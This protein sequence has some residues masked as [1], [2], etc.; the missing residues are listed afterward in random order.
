MT[1][2]Y[3]V[4]LWSG[5][6]LRIK[7]GLNQSRT[8]SMTTVFVHNQY[9]KRNKWHQHGVKTGGSQPYTWPPTQESGG[10]L[11]PPDLQDRRHCRTEPCHARSI[12]IRSKCQE[13]KNFLIVKCKKNEKITLYASTERRRK[14]RAELAS[15]MVHCADFVHNPP[16]ITTTTQNHG[17]GWPKNAARAQN[18]GINGDRNYVIFTPL[19]M[20]HRS[21]KSVHP[22][23]PVGVTKRPKKIQ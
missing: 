12:Q 19:R 22:L 21:L 8:W 6:R 13:S 11:W 2:R 16:I 9:I 14:T 4:I 3:D 20:T 5:M 15:K 10:V 1:V 18:C 23:R 7:V 17:D